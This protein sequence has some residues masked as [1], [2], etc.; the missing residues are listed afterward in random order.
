MFNKFYKERSEEGQGLVEYALILVLVSITVIAVLSLLGDNVGAV[1]WRVDAALS[2][3]IVSGSGNEY[4]IGGF[5]ANPSGGPAVCT[6]Q[7]P[8]FTVTMLQNGQAASAGQSVSVSIVATGGGSKSASATT[9]ASG[10]AVFGAQSVQGNCSGTV[11]ITASGS[12]RS[13]S[14]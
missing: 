12:S 3:Q 7:V 5:S 14:Y 11:T 2:G 6:V 9:D 1:F 10:Q 13:A 4:V 8:S